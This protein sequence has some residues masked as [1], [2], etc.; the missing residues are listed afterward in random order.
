MHP[1]LVRVGLI[2]VACATLQ[3]RELARSAAV[4]PQPAVVTGPWT[5]HGPVNL[6]GITFSLLFDPAD[7]NVLWSGTEEGMWKSSDGGGQWSVVPSLDGIGVFAL[8]RDPRDGNKMYAGTA[9]SGIFRS[10]DRG[11][12]WQKLAAAAEYGAIDSIAISARDGSLL[13]GARRGILRSTDSGLT[14]QTVR[15]VTS[16]RTSLLIDPL[17]AN[18]AIA[19]VTRGNAASGSLFLYSN[20]SG[21]TWQQA[22]GIDTDAD[23]V[24]SAYAPSQSTLVYAITNRARL[25]STIWRSDDGG[26]TFIRVAAA[27]QIASSG[28]SRVE[29]WV[30]PVD[31]RHLII[32]AVSEW[33]SRDGG[34]TFVPLTP[35]RS[36]MAVPFPHDDNNGIASDPAYDAVTN[37]RLFVWTDGGVFRTDDLG[38][39]PPTWVPLHRNHQST[40]Y[41]MIDVSAR[42]K[43]IGGMQD[44]GISIQQPG[45]VEAEHPFDADVA[46]IAFDALDDARFYVGIGGK[47][48][49]SDRQTLIADVSQGASFGFGT[50]TPC[51]ID[52][53][54]P[55]RIFVAAGSIARIDNGR[56]STIR[57]PDGIAIV[58]IAVQRGDSNVVW[59]MNGSGTIFRTRNALSEAPSWETMQ[60]R[61]LAGP[62]MLLI[63]AADPNTVYA[64]SHGG[65]LK[66]TDG[67]RTW[68]PDRGMRD[69]PPT[70]LPPFVND[71][72]Q[73]PVNRSVLYAGTDSGLYVSTDSAATWA[74]A[75]GGVPSIAS[76]RSL[77][78]QPGTTRLY[79]GTYGRG[80]WSTETVAASRRRTVRH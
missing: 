35:Q 71:L 49:L 72:A 59:A 52:T 20:D 22:T 4:A 75:P 40:Q 2:A 39:S 55:S 66:T 80:I 63:D 11:A 73:H 6:A 45:A 38:A 47:L 74:M 70:A 69:Q 30:S 23:V 29:L 15:S 50:P 19:S 51:V 62:T 21:V 31:P 25:G 10:Y 14:V 64:A 77:R 34:A 76:V 28:R 67:G 5:S 17:D 24:V 43:I 8:A 1:A 36:S 9:A 27:L 78:F 41:Y 16:L 42:G 61:V 54:M 58:A 60:S 32:G 56:V 68:I 18:R 57:P 7:S 53:N 33:V 37:R 48:Y 44:T 46:S 26:R 12:T 13:I 79:V 3:A 65:I